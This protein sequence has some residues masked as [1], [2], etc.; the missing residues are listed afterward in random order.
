MGPLCP[1]CISVQIQFVCLSDLL[2][3]KVLEDDA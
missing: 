1:Y 2:G 3:I